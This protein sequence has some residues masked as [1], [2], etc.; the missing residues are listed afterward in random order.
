MQK[1]IDFLIKNLSGK[2]FKILGCVVDVE[3]DVVFNEGASVSIEFRESPPIS[4]TNGF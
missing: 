4:M 2:S 1:P 3:E